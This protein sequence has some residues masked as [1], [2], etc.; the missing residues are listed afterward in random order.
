MKTTIVFRSFLQILFV[1]LI[2]SVS[3]NAQLS[4][5]SEIEVNPRDLTPEQTEKYQ[6]ILDQETVV[7]TKFIKIGELSEM[8]QDGWLKLK[9]PDKDCVALVRAK[10]VESSED[11]DYYWYGEVIKNA[12]GEEEC[13]CFDG[14]INL[15]KK[16]GELIGTITIDEDNYEI[17]SVGEGK[18]VLAKKDAA[19][20]NLGC[21][22]SDSERL[23]FPTDV[24]IPRNG[25]HC[26]VRVLGLF[27]PNA[28]NAVSDI[29][30]TIE[31][32]IAQ[33][34]QAFRNSRIYGSSLE[35]VLVDV[36]EIQFTE[37][38]GARTDRDAL[39]NDPTV[40]TLRNN[41]DADIVLVYTDGNYGTVL[42][43]AGTLTL[44]AERALALIQAAE[45]TNDYVTSHEIA[46]LFAC[47]HEIDADATGPFEHAHEFKTGCWPFRKKRNTIMYS[48]ATGKSIQYYSNPNVEFKNKPTGVSD[49]T[50]NARQLRAN[51]CTVAG[52]RAGDP[53][54]NANIV[55]EEYGCPCYFAYLRANVS[56]GAPGSYQY[57]W[58]TSTDG[59]NWSGVQSTSYAF[60]IMAP[61]EVGERI[62]IQLIV[63]SSDGQL[64]EAFGFIESAE[65]WP[66]QQVDCD[67]RFSGNPVSGI[68]QT[69]PEEYSV[70]P[71]PASDLITVTF[72]RK[73]TEQYSDISIL[74]IYG[75]VVYSGKIFYDSFVGQV[76][77]DINEFPNGVYFVKTEQDQTLR[78]VKSDI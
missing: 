26:T 3:L 33:T 54:L 35:L 47:R 76:D 48:T 59:F 18:T 61:C 44:Q 6:K 66:G 11:G 52:F 68:S 12:E 2:V 57:E 32:S 41:A 72:P 1:V 42:G 8:Q 37:G 74:N 16:R 34:N 21:G 49:E 29:E 50:E 36:Q 7:F 71:N 69:L 14:S 19:I 31:L 10:H 39:I 13:E 70:F 45:A 38:F 23:N 65:R 28:N 20:L 22:N 25:G 43:I 24:S 63:T 56:G 75:Q 15:M 46:H 64:D 58:R 30:N 5:I 53:S 40:Q 78:F 67:Q 62:F 27:T 60:S 4:F 51:A 17:Q 77:I 9:M 55:G 73:T